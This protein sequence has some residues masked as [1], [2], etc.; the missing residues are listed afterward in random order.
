MQ[1]WFTTCGHTKFQLHNRGCALSFNKCLFMFKWNVHC[2]CCVWC[3]IGNLCPCLSFWLILWLWLNLW[4][5]HVK[6]LAWCERLWSV[7]PLASHQELSEIKNRMFM[8]SAPQSVNEQVISSCRGMAP[9]FRGQEAP[10]KLRKGKCTSLQVL[11]CL[12]LSA[13]KGVTQNR[14]ATYLYH[15][16]VFLTLTARFCTF[17]QRATVC[18]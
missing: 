13:C 2:S 10:H 6:E 1:I 14:L 8:F 7:V 11:L 16:Q 5:H 17:N 4:F 3:L 15:F 18:L 12:I 9:C